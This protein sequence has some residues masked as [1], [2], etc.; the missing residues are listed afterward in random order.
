[1]KRCAILVCFKMSLVD[2]WENMKYVRKWVL[3]MKL[4]CFSDDNGWN[5]CISWVS[6]WRNRKIHY[7]N[8]KQ[9]GPKCFHVNINMICNNTSILHLLV[10]VE[11]CGSSVLEKIYL[12]L[13][14]FKNSYLVILFKLFQTFDHNLQMWMLFKL[15]QSFDNNLQMWML[16]SDNVKIEILRL[17]NLI[18]FGLFY[19]LSNVSS[20]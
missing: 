18:H 12:Y 14:T 16:T 1:M 19:H 8:V 6:N 20:G 5:K 4:S 17:C 15:F 13:E 7:R 3:E 10:Q 9:M 2:A 11:D